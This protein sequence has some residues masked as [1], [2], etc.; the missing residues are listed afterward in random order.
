MCN[1]QY[2][3]YQC[4][5]DFNFHSNNQMNNDMNE[6]NNEM[7]DKNSKNIIYYILIDDIYKEYNNIKNHNKIICYI[8][9]D[10][11]EY[12]NDDSNDNTLY[13]E[14]NNNKNNTETFYDSVYITEIHNDLHSKS[15]IYKKINPNI[16]KNIIKQALSYYPSEELLQNKI[17]YQQN[18]IYELYKV[19]KNNNTITESG[20]NL[21][22]SY[23]QEIKHKINIRKITMQATNLL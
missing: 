7:N 15:W 22:N 12:Y 16:A 17:I 21:I 23:I 20:E 1:N 3:I 5:E 10:V 9:K 14:N 4:Y 19:Y 18:N 8:N 6:M 13:K 11:I 2:Y